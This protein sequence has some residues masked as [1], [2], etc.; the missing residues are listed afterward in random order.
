MFFLLS[1]YFF[2][3]GAGSR[4]VVRF[5]FSDGNRNQCRYRDR[6]RLY[7]RH[8]AIDFDP[9]PDIEIQLS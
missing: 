1:S 5:W 6:N 4:R 9:E 7:S 8:T 3:R 2:L